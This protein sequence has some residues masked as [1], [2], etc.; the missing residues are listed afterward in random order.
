MSQLSPEAQQLQESLNRVF[1]QVGEAF[2]KL[3]EPRYTM[4]EIETAIKAVE[5]GD[6]WM[7][8][9]AVKRELEAGRVR[10]RVA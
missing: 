5:Q 3:G 8:W 7:C 2:K 10:D 6:G 4:A 1:A 9:W